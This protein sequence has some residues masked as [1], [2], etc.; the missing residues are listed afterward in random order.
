M[1]SFL[2]LLLTIVAPNPHPDWMVGRWQYIGPAQRPNQ[3]CNGDG[4]GD[5][6][7]FSRRGYW[8][9]VALGDYGKWWISGDKLF[10]RTIDHGE[11][12]L[13]S[14]KGTTQI[15]R[16]RLVGDGKLRLDNGAWYIR[17]GRDV[18]GWF[19]YGKPF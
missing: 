18:D 2:A 17:C 16:I 4:G 7:V 1:P 19:P 15:D 13:E 12:G 3:A 5:Q 6:V 8:V 9:G 10:Q 14:D 11:A